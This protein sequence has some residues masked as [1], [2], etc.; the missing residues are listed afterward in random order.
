[1]SQL[2]IALAAAACIGP[3]FVARVSA[4]PEPVAAATPDLARQH[5]LSLASAAHT[6]DIAIDDAV[7]VLL[8]GQQLS[9]NGAAAG[10][11]VQAVQKQLPQRLDDLLEVLKYRRTAW[12]SAHPDV[13]FPGVVLLWLDR[14]T[15]IFVVKSIYQT[16]AFAGYPNAS[17]AVRPI[18]KPDGLERI[19]AD[20]YVPRPPA[21]ESAETLARDPFQLCVEAVF[22]QEVS[23]K[24]KLNETVVR[25]VTVAER[26]ELGTVAFPQLAARV[27]EEWT[28]HG[29]HRTRYDVDFDEASVTVANELTF[30]S[31]IGLIDALYTPM[32]DFEFSGERVSVPA[33]NVIVPVH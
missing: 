12:R 33:F 30:E 15:P 1:M 4:A 29:G 18:G 32:R 28:A 20:A 19:N 23:L 17:F 3:S 24:W 2:L 9:V 31:M 8:E 5:G 10:T 16:A 26:A 21:T 13:G 27:A 22:G 25:T 11:T 14:K 7:N 6:M